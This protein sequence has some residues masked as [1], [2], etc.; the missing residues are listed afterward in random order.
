MREVKFNQ[1]NKPLTTDFHSNRWSAHKYEDGEEGP[2]NTHHTKMLAE[3]R[4]DTRMTCIPRK[5]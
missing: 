3:G 2:G 4:T 5:T 1:A